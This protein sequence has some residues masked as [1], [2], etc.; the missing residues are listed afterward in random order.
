MHQVEPILESA[1]GT[2]SKVVDLSSAVP[3]MPKALMAAVAPQPA[4]PPVVINAPAGPDLG[5]LKSLLAQAEASQGGGG[6]MGM[7]APQA[8]AAPAAEE[9]GGLEALLGG[10]GGGGGG[11]LERGPCPVLFFFDTPAR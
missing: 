1:I 5:Q 2:L 8:P 3:A 11:A 4:P 9:S 6:G 7:F 10:L